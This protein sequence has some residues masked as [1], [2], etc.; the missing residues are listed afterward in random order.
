MVTKVVIISFIDHLILTI[1]VSISSLLSVLWY[2]KT[3]RSKVNDFKQVSKHFE[4]RTGY[5]MLSVY[6]PTTIS[7]KLLR[8]TLALPN[9]PVSLV[10]SL[11]TVVFEFLISYYCW[12]EFQKFPFTIFFK[13]IQISLFK[14]IGYSLFLIVRKI[15]SNAVKTRFSVIWAIIYLK[16]LFKDCTLISK[17]CNCCLGFNIKPNLL[18]TPSYIWHVMN[19]CLETSRYSLHWNK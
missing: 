7:N 19:W 6:I 8:L 13:K 16:T 3:V 12:A 14:K 9:N 18:S 1:F 10:R 15:S 2:L 4:K 5:S 17:L 11:L